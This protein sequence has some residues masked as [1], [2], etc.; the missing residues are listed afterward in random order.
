M[1]RI[2]VIGRAS[3]VAGY[4]LA[5]AEV[6]DAPHDVDATRAWDELAADVTL[7]LLSA[8]ARRALPAS[9]DAPGRLWAVLPE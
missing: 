7:V 8:A 5:G 9:L 6:V 1:T 3:D 2:V 4:E